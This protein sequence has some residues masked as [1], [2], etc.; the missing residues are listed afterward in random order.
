MEVCGGRE[1]VGGGAGGDRGAGAEGKEGGVGV[2]VCD[3]GVERFGGVG[4]VAGRSETLRA[5][6]GEDECPVV[7]SDGRGEAGDSDARGH[8]GR[9]G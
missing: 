4:E 8:S 5:G 6:G 1:A 7:G 3:E 9:G 2:D